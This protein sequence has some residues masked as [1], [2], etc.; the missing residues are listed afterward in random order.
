MLQQAKVVVRLGIPDDG[1]ELPVTL[2]EVEVDG[3]LGYPLS[4]TA[5]IV[6]LTGRLEEYLVFGEEGGHDAVE[7]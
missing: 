3:C 2:D 1:R 5:A 7:D 6:A 4:L